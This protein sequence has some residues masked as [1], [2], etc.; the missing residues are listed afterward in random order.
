METKHRYH[1]P[2]RPFSPIDA[3]N[4]RAAALGSPSYASGASHADYNGHHVTVSW[5]EYR[6]YYV[7]EY[8]WAGRIVLARGSAEECTAAAVA[9]YNRGALGASVDVSL[10]GDEDSE[11]VLKLFP[12]LASGPCEFA[13]QTSWYTWRHECAASAARDYANPRLAPMIFDWDLMQAA[14]TRQAYVAA[15]REKHGRVYT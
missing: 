4:R 12:Q 14:E 9:E 5:N 8:T 3:L 1:L 7:C 6:K 2:V 11:R 13:H 15:L 10:V